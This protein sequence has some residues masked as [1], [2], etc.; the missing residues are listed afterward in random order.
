MVE[1]FDKRID[2]LPKTEISFS[3]IKNDIKGG[4]NRMLDYNLFG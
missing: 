3:Q 2:D 4:M 1:S